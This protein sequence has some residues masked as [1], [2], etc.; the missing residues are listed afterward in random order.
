MGEKRKVSVEGVGG[1]RTRGLRSHSR[2]NDGTRVT[3]VGRAPPHPRDDR[4]EPTEGTAV[5]CE[6]GGQNAWRERN[7]KQGGGGWGE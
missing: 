6:G 2:R 1:L 7:V 3:C 4:H 5:P